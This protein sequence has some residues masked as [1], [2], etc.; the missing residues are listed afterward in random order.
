MQAKFFRRIILLSVLSLISGYLQAQS[1]EEDVKTVIE[2]L[3]DGMRAA[4][5]SMVSPL[6][7]SNAVLFT[8]VEKDDK[9]MLPQLAVENFL[10]AVGTARNEVWDERI[11]AY[12]IKV[13][14][15]LAS[16]WTPYE[17]YRGKEFSHCGVNTFQL[18]KSQEGWKIISITDNRRKDN[19]PR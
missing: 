7:A 12:D 11:L 15:K 6:F 13:D 19:C 8:I 18:Y 1:A 4:D 10:N 3:F 2:Q 5:S 9:V 16:A 14:E 17:F